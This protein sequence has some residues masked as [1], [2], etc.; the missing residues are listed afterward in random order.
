MGIQVDVLR[1]NGF[2]G[3]ENLEI[4]LPKVAILFGQNNA[5]KTSIIKALQL[6]LGDYGRYLSSEDFF[7]D[8]ADDQQVDKITVDI[9]IIPIDE[10]GR[11]KTFEDDWVNVFGEIIQPDLDEYDYVALRA[12]AKQHETLQGKYI[13]EREYLTEWNDFDNWLDSDTLKLTKKL[14]E[15]T[16]IPID[17][18][19]DI[20]SEIKEKYSFIGRVLSNI[21]YSSSEI[22]ELE[23]KIAEINQNAVDKS[24]NLTHLKTH[25]DKL[26]ETTLGRGKTEIMP[27]PKK[28]RDLSKNFSLHFGDNANSSFSMEY[29]GMG[30][31]SWASMLTVKA[32]TEMLRDSFEKESKAFFSLIAAEEPEAHL[33]PN[34]QRTLYNQLA[35][36]ENQVIVSTHSPYL[37]SM[38]DFSQLRALYKK[39]GRVASYKLTENLNQG[40]KNTLKRAVLFSRGELMFSRVLVLAEGVTEEQVLP[41]LIQAYFGQSCSALGINC[42][43]VGGVNYAPFIKMAVSFGIPVVVI[44]DNESNINTKVNKVIANIIDKFNLVLSSDVFYLQFLQPNNNFESELLGLYLR[45]EIIDA[46]MLAYK[47]KDSDEIHRQIKEQE[48]NSSSNEQLFKE[49]KS[50]KSTYSGFL[51]DIILENPYNK[52]FKTLLSLPLN[53]AFEKIA[54]W[55]K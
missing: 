45:N 46:L 20:H 29:H 38:A 5:G 7:I 53:N 3:I 2:R 37:I 51:A 8:S 21:N 39:D 26:S 35:S 41:S 32:F 4:T 28:I 34:A 40:E 54:E 36:M 52:D 55:I 10:N 11:V 23:E 14:D 31:R 17:A 18:Q 9:R 43:G 19:R 22:E 47:E 42:I 27:F 44:S 30:T 16:F 24:A 12:I 6:V 15:I 50:S 1:I 13:T 33:H 49:M 48:L 25:L